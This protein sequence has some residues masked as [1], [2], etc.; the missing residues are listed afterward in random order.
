[1]KA[2]RQTLAVADDIKA[3]KATI[4]AHTDHDNLRVK[5]CMELLGGQ[6]TAKRRPWR[7]PPAFC[8]FSIAQDEVLVKACEKRVGSPWFPGHSPT[9]NTLSL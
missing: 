7:P 9:H 4:T 8:D 6:T 3:N 1:M 5:Q 2:N